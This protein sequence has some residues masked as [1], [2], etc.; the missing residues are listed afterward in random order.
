MT[1][2]ECQVQMDKG[3]LYVRG[4]GSSLARSSDPK[5]RFF[6]KKGLDLVNLTELS[7]TP[8][9]GQAVLDASRCPHCNRRRLSIEVASPAATCRLN[10]HLQPAT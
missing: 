2:P 5:I 10:R 4:I 3:F 9:G 7:R 6:S 8:T 1:C